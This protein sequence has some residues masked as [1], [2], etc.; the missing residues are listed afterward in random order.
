MMSIKFVLVYLAVKRKT[1]QQK[2][3]F[4]IKEAMQK[5]IIVLKFIMLHVKHYSR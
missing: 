4:E 1:V 2:V 5:V 3:F